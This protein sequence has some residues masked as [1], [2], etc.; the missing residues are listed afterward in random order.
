MEPFE[1]PCT[2]HQLQVMMSIVNVLMDFNKALVPASLRH[3][4]TMPLVT[5]ANIYVVE[6]GNLYDTALNKVGDRYTLT[7]YY[8]LLFKCRETLLPAI[9]LL[10][11]ML[12]GDT[13]IE[14]T[15]AGI[16]LSSLLVEA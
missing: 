16:R 14:S 10:E 13:D 1:E 4:I 7:N 6:V 15:M 12:S 2:L 9:G 8:E 11:G 3:G 5:V